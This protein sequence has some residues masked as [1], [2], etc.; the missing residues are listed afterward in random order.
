[1]GFNAAGTTVALHATNPISV[2]VQGSSMALKI[3]S[4][5]HWLSRWS[6]R[7]NHIDVYKLYNFSNI[8]IGGW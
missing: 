2:M 4:Y 5:L 7:F 8:G 1:M 6:T 3:S